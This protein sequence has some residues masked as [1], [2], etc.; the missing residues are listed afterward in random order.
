M[1]RIQ[2]HATRVSELQDSVEHA[3]QAQQIL[4]N[5]QTQILSEIRTEFVSRESHLLDSVIQKELAT[6]DLT[7]RLAAAHTAQAECEAS[8]A[9]LTSQL[10]EA[11]NR[12]AALQAA[13]TMQITAMT[14]LHSQQES[15]CR[16]L[17]EKVA[18]AEQLA[19]PRSRRSLRSQPSTPLARSGPDAPMS[20]A[21]SSVKFLREDEE[22]G[23]FSGNIYEREELLDEDVDV[24][25]QLARTRD[26]LKACQMSLSDAQSQQRAAADQLAKLTSQHESVSAEYA[27]SRAELETFRLEL[28]TRVVEYVLQLETSDRHL[29]DTTRALASALS[30]VES[31]RLE[32]AGLNANSREH[33][34]AVTT[35]KAHHDDLLAQLNDA[36]AQLRACETLLRTCQL[37]LS[38]SQARVSLAQ[39]QNTQFETILVREFGQDILVRVESCVFI[40]N[41]F[42]VKFPE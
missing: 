13:H 37:E 24:D 32:V 3:V 17:E 25:V 23:A 18:V 36:T 9:A 4:Q 10:T 7:S 35:L 8:V 41:M 34:A 16:D 15:K 31:L 42:C 2:A 19:S 30:D 20:P 12:I 11:S 40:L 26:E 5:S 28:S 21:S 33:A 6:Q 29:K 1:H 27:A 22:Q 39:L 14:A 38:E